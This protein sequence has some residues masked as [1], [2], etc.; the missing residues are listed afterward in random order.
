MIHNNEKP[1]R[2]FDRINKICKIGLLPGSARVDARRYGCQGSHLVNLVNPVKNAHVVL[3]VFVSLWFSPASFGQSIARTDPN[4]TLFPDSSIVDFSRLLDAPAGK[5]GFLQTGPNGKFSWSDGRRAKFWGVNISNKSVWTTHDT[6]DHVVDVLA[7]AG[8]NMVRF[9]AID[10]FGALLDVDGSD[11]TRK[12]DRRKLA[13]LDYWTSKLR[14]RGIYYYFDLLDFR[15]FKPGDGVPEYQQLGRAAKPYAFFDRRLID[16]QKEYARQLLTHKNPHTGLRYVDDPALALVEIC[17]EH[18]LFFKAEMLDSLVE[19]YGAQLR[20]LWNR[21]LLQ[22]YGSRDGIRTVWGQLG[23]MDALQPSEDPGSYSVGLPLFT[24]ALP[25]DPAAPQGQPAFVDVRRAPAR[26]RDGVRFL[27]EMQRGYFSEMK[28]ALRDLGLKVPVTG[29]VSNEMVPDVASAAAECDF[30][31]EN[32][33]ADHPTFAGKEWQGSYFF[34]DA[35]P[36][37]NSSPYMVAPWLAALRW[38]NKP[39]VVR[40]WATVWPN[41]YRAI[42]IPEIAAYASLQ[43]LDA[44]LL[45]GY[46]IARDPNMLSDFDHQ[47]DPVVWGLFGMGAQMFLRG[48]VAAAPYALDVEYSRDTLFRWPNGLTNLDR[49]AWFVRVNSRVVDLPQKSARVSKAGTRR[50]PS[51][52]LLASRAGRPG[53]P[54]RPK[55][56][57]ENPLRIAIA[58]DDPASLGDVLDRFGAL[59]AP[60]GRK[61][62]ENGLLGAS[63][64]Q[65][66]RFQNLGMLGV[67]TPRAIALC[68]ELP[69]N[70]ALPIGSFT[71]VSPTP[72]AALMAVSL[73]GK[74]L[75][76]SRQYIVKMV[77]RAENTNQALEP[78][79]AGAPGKFRLKEWGKAPVLTF[80][81]PGKAMIL[82]HNGKPILSLGMEEG[83]WE[84]L[85]KDGRATLVCDTGSIR[86]TLLGKSITTT[87]SVAMDVESPSPPRAAANRQARRPAIVAH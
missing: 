39:V 42:A 4:A 52:R 86:G 62:L 19:P 18:G 72:I 46:Q 87:Q 33:Y 66:V 41:H 47:C 61:M 38:E 81:R 28:A 32:Y 84:L 54:E 64:G 82:K 85:V 50:R 78:A 67:E 14:E 24:P 43:D 75:D 5:N 23:G 3:C 79:P 16:L 80:G 68:G 73:D 59:G 37:R 53:R 10:S 63:N 12:L 31:S 9:E 7:R 60:V 8:A 35:N 6:I 29:V 58:A 30:T 76:R 77:S 69:T 70:R 57:P 21:W 65:V 44:V 27:Y 22:Q 49:A 13:T 51:G 83:T 45:F 17:N 36:L 71:L 15:Q 55:A 34:N 40:E 56:T 74:P 11:S 20:Q 26:L 25:P 2:F 48:D 1:L